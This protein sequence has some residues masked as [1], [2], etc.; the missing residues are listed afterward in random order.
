MFRPTI[1]AALLVTAIAA[2][3]SNATYTIDPTH[4]FAT[5]EISHY[6]TSTNRG[7]FDRKEGTVQLDKSAKTGRVEITIDTTSVNTGVP[8][9]DKHL[10]SK[11]FFDSAAY[12]TATFVGDRFTFDGDKVVAVSGTLT[13]RGETQPLTLKATRFNCY[14]NPL[15]RRETCGGDFVATLKR[16]EWGVDYGLKIGFPDEMRLLIQVEAIKQ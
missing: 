16:S 5:Y 15:L 6:G 12:P 13:L 3:A 9:L 8:Q 14:T 11:D 1:A 4:T 10:Q 2:Q 7:R